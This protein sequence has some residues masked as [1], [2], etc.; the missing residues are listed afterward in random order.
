MDTAALWIWLYTLLFALAHSLLASDKVKQRV[1]KL[2]LQAH[3]YRL[4]YSLIGVLTTGLW[5]W[6]IAGLPD[7]PLYVVDGWWRFALYALQG[8]GVLIALAALQPID[9]AVFLGLKKAEQTDPFVVQGIYQ[10]IRHPMY[11][12]VMLFLLAKPDMT[13]NSLHFA[14]AVSV[15]FVIGSR[16]EEK[17]MLAEHPGYTDYQQK[18]GAFLPKLF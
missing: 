9:G 3:H 2:G 8:L 13:V 14:L 10:Y 11:A 1:Y 6:A 4:I 18:V 7:A 15:Y 12:G 5:L 17:R 16:L